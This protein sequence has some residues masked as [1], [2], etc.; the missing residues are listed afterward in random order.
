MTLEEL[1]AEFE[2]GTLRPGY[3]L[4]GSELLLRDDAFAAIRN[5]VLDGAADDFNLDRL[6]GAV[7]PTALL[8]VVRTLPVMGARRLVVLRDPDVGRGGKAL[9]DA[10]PEALGECDPQRGSVLVVLSVRADARTKW[11]KAF[12]KGRVDCEAPKR[13]SDVIAFVRAEAECQGIALERAAADLLVERIGPQLLLLRH[14]LAKAALMAGEGEKVTR[15]HV[16]AGAL[17]VAEDPVWDLTDAI[18]EGR[19]G[20]ALAVLSRL[21]AGGAAPP[22]LLGSLVGHFRRLLQVADGASPPV[23]P[24]VRRKLET[25]ARRYG[26]RRLVGCM[27][28]IHQTDLAL[29]GAGGLRSDLAMERLVLGLAG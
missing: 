29:K 19:T 5:A 8:D 24:F 2:A 11:V 22:M 7:R 27:R 6:E 18:G 15:A 9:L 13:V 23:P 14:E 17:D 16:A 26:A 12:G 25:Q 28:A 20:D 4:A 3:L 10:L 1:H 21:L